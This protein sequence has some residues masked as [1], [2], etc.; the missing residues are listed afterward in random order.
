MPTLNPSSIVAGIGSEP[1]GL[2]LVRTIPR[3]RRQPV[4]Q[5]EL[6]NEII[7]ERLLEAHFQP[8]VELQTGK[9]LGYEGLIRGPAGTPLRAPVEL[10]EIAATQGQILRLERLCRQIV[11]ESYAALALPNKLF[12]NVRP[13]CLALPTMG[14][15]GTVDL[16][17]RLGLKP[18]S[19]VIELT[20]NQPFSD[21]FAI[22]EVLCAYRKLGFNIAIDDLGEGFASFR[23]WSELRPEYVKADMHF[24]QG[25]DSD[26]FKLQFLKAVQRIAETCDSLIVAEGVE[27]VAELSV[28]R[29][30][31]IA[32]GQGN[33][34]APPAASPPNRIPE[35]VL[36]L[37]SGP[38]NV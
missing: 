1:Q 13:H 37:L 27:K 10:F 5:V 17:N 14:A 6:L 32:F 34:I 28:I 20:E 23:L 26:P 7:E 19:I 31:G 21:Y 29:D 4:D 15:A 25:I 24:I 9:I 36:G 16:L 18:D 30:L 33:L 35:Q 11:L 12:L 8:I 2:A 38:R 3:L 22:R